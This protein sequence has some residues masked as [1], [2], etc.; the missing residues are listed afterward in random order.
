MLSSRTN[1]AGN[2]TYSS[3][4]VVEPLS[5]N[6][7]A[8]IVRR[9][10]RVRT[11]GTRHCFN[12]IA[13]TAGIHISLR[14]MNR[15]DPVD[16]QRKTVTLEGG[17]RYGELVVALNAQGWA[18]PNMASLPHI[19]VVGACATATHGS[20]E[21]RQALHGPVCAIQL[22]NGKGE[23]VE[24]SRDGDPDLFP[25]C[26]VNLG[27]LG[28]V[29]RITLDVIPAYTM[30]QLVYRSLAVEDVI[31]EFDSIQR[32]GA[33]VSFFTAWNGDR[34]DQLWLKKLAADNQPDDEVVCGGRLSKVNLHPVETV[35][36]EPCTEQ[37][38]VP[39]AWHER[40]PHFKLEFTP[41]VGA[42]LQSEYLV[43]REHFEHAFRALQALQSRIHPLLLISEIRTI[44]ADDQWMSPF[45]RQPCV[46]FHFTWKPL[47][48]AVLALLPEMES[49]L[50]PFG[51]RP[52]WG[53][54]YTMP[55][56]ALRDLYP[57]YEEFKA[58]AMEF[59]PAGRY[60]N[61]YLNGLFGAG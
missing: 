3:S 22:V 25:A 41:S 47:P 12:A 10:H 2:I 7:V 43:P 48:A 32:K 16:R 30:R 1:W 17:V 42:E 59:D 26:A 46:A 38:G 8:E 19:S 36:S 54:L 34:I 13:D 55:F 31:S 45:Y 11:I 9:S 50:R 39:G 57:K 4:E 58:V 29:T 21:S 5:V 15:I 27:A 49:A 60:R 35:G 14:R 18:L 44:A 33:S 53:K 37:M 24:L 40:L 61:G 23:I 56:D 28:T 20:G 6:E 51:A 52:H